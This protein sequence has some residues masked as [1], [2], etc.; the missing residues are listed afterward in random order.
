MVLLA[1]TQWM[2]SQSQRFIDEALDVEQKP[3]FLFFG[4][5][6]TKVTNTYESLFDNSYLDTPKGTLVGAEVPDDTLM[7]SREG[8]WDMALAHAGKNP[9]DE[10]M[11]RF[12]DRDV[13]RLHD[14]H[15]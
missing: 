8:I 10:A 14:G 9:K 6:L 2:V 1:I 4:S 15:L 13:D 11:N 3:F 7:S 12:V 5:T